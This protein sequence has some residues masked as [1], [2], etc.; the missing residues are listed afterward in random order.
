M[1]GDDHKA[2]HQPDPAEERLLR[3]LRIITGVVILTMIVLLVI[4][5]TL[6][7]LLV[8]PDFH[9]SE[10]ILGTLVGALML[11]LGIEGLTRLPGT[12]NGG[13]R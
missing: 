7:R 3:R 1:A 5:D 12:K 4:A 11:L 6:G 13:G 9:A 8:S 10:L 2:S